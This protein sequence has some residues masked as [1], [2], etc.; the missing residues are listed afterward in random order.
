LPQGKAGGEALV[1]R[2]KKN[3]EVSDKRAG[4]PREPGTSFL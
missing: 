3:K 4:F 2:K 1:L